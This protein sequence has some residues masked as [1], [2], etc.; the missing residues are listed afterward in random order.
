LIKWIFR[1]FIL[2]LIL[3]IG[4]GIFAYF[5][6]KATQPPDI[7]DA[8][9]AIQLYYEVEGMRFPTRYYYTEKIEINDG[10]AILSNYWRYDGARYHKIKDEKVVEP[11]F[12]IIRRRK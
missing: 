2:G 9:Y 10:K 1:I 11:P 12:D 4:L 3:V 7:K 5:N 8:P 6:L